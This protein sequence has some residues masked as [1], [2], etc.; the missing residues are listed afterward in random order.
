MKRKDL[1]NRNIVEFGMYPLRYTEEMGPVEW[2]IFRLE[3][4]RVY[5]VSKDVLDSVPFHTK[6][7][8]VSW[9]DSFLREWLN[10]AF[11]N[12]AF[13]EEEQAELMPVMVPSERVALDGY[14]QQAVSVGEEETEDLV[15]IPG[16]EDYAEQLSAAMRKSR[17]TE[18]AEKHGAYCHPNTDYGVW[19]L[20]VSCLS[21]KSVGVVLPDGYASYKTGVEVTAED[22]GV[23]PVICLRL[24]TD[25]VPAEIEKDPL[26]VSIDTL[27]L[28]VRQWNC[29][30][31][32]GI[33]TLRDLTERTAQ[34]IRAV[35]NL[36]ADGADDLLDKM[37][38]AGILP[39]GIS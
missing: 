20:R 10:C 38:A 9:K 29:L 12:I 25:D 35:R 11:L 39:M 8:P 27:G 37:A 13:T 30:K 33:H 24:E 15:Y 4:D 3:E 14:G 21:A 1:E 23:R 2:R 22:V 28:S 32:A 16:Y 34:E 19:W 36:G 7:D 31:R 26:D 17:P 6:A 5:L 18:Y